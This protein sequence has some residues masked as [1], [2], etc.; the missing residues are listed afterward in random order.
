MNLSF[1]YHS[2]HRTERETCNRQGLKAGAVRRLLSFAV[3]CV[4]VLSSATQSFAVFNDIEG[5]WAKSSIIK[6]YEYGLFEG[7]GNGA[8]DPNRMISRSEFITVMVRALK[9]EMVRVDSPYWASTY[10]ATAKK[11]GFLPQDYDESEA[12]GAEEI[13][14]LEMMRYLALIVTKL[15]LPLNV[16]PPVISDMDQ[17]S[18]EDRAL[19]EIT[20]KSGVIQGTSE[21]EVK[22]YLLTSRAEA[23]TVLVRIYD[24]YL[25]QEPAPTIP[26]PSVSSGTVDSG[27]RIGMYFSDEAA[28]RASYRVNPHLTWKILKT[29]DAGHF[30]FVL[31]NNEK[32]VVASS[33]SALP[34]QNAASSLYLFPYMEYNYGSRCFWDFREWKNQVGVEGSIVLMEI[35]PAYKRQMDTAPETEEQVFG[36]ERVTEYITNCFRAQKNRALFTFHEPGHAFAKRFSQTMDDR[37]VFDHDMPGGPS[38]VERVRTSGIDFVSVGENIAF[39]FNDPVTLSIVWINSPGH[40]VNIMDDRFETCSV[41]VVLS[42]Y[43]GVLATQTF[44]ELP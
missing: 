4:L 26:S 33:A 32:I 37:N 16:Q 25:A 39:G 31:L 7:V 6:S 10:I 35:D 1:L 19:I 2:K 44:L 24:A 8:F 34:E 42:K 36:F 14:R 12:Y 23:A 30:A 21:G 20:L 15:N 41:G 29:A 38:F 22:P 40:R 43:R 11:H 3:L 9:P 28:V 13:T 27:Y 5:H 17:L 18:E